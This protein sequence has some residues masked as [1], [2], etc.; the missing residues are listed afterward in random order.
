MPFDA[1]IPAILTGSLD[2]GIS[3]FT[4][5]DERK[6]RLSFSLPYIDAG[7]GIMINNKFKDTILSADDLKGRKLCAQIGTSGAMYSSKVPNAQV[8]QFNSASETYLELRKGGCDAIV[9]DRPV[10]AYYMSTVMPDN[11]SLL[12]GYI[13]SESY[14]I[15]VNKSNRELLTLIDDGLKKIKEDG[16]YDKIYKKWFESKSK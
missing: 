12:D 14:G 4:I 13:S 2:A 3:A 16:T 8:T 5:T 6:K 7:L 1:L 11:V 9:N 10:H 15:V